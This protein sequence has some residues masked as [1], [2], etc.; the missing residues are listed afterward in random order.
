MKDKLML[1]IDNSDITEEEK[2]YLIEYTLKNL[3]IVEEF[4]N[5]IGILKN[6]F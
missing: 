6:I 2:K 4:Q 3:K 1:M 5:K